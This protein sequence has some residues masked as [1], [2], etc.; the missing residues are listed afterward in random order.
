LLP[1]KESIRPGLSR[2]VQLTYFTSGAGRARRCAGCASR[3]TET[4]SR[5]RKSENCRRWKNR[6]ARPDRQPDHRWNCLSPEPAYVDPQE[7]SGLT[8]A[9]ARYHNRLLTCRLVRASFESALLREWKLLGI[10]DGANRGNSENCRPLPQ[11]DRPPSPYHEGEKS[12]RHFRLAPGVCW[13]S[14]SFS[15][16]FRCGKFREALP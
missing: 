16:A 13:D 10:R 14:R 4:G 15:L 6:G 12:R 3:R 11:K 7:D 5:G 8:R 2:S 9:V 1:F